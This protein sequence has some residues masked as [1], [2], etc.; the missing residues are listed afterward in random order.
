MRDIH[1]FA[2]DKGE[3]ALAEVARKRASDIDAES[4]TSGV[5][6]LG[7]LDRGDMLNEAFVGL[8]LVPQGEDTFPDNLPPFCSIHKHIIQQRTLNV[9]SNRQVLDRRNELEKDTC[10]ES[11]TP[12]TCNKEGVNAKF[13]VTGELASMNSLCKTTSGEMR[14]DCIEQEI[15]DGGSLRMVHFG[16]V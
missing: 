15:G 7:P 8:S 14:E 11:L 3:L 16:L 13:E 5:E 2:L 9:S 4:I 10:A 6:L 12:K 1:Y